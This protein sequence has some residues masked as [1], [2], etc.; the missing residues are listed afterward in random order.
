MVMACLSVP[1]GSGS[2]I[3]EVLRPEGCRP[4]RGT[5]VWFQ[6]ERVQRRLRAMNSGSTASDGAISTAFRRGII[7]KDPAALEQLVLCRTSSVRG[8]D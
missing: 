3:P 4:A 6:S 1:R 2:H 5:G 8:I 7:V